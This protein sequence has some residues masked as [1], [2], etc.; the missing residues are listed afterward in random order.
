MALYRVP[1]HFFFHKLCHKMTTK[2]LG[3]FNL[4]RD[5]FTSLNLYLI[6]SI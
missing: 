4:R 2:E 3:M 5:L 1:M 6:T